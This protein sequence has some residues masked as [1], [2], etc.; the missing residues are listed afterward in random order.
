MNF[1]SIYFNKPFWKTVLPLAIPIALQNLMAASFSLIDTFMVAGLGSTTLSAVGMATQYTWLFNICIF[2][3]TSG[4]ALF[5]SQYWGTKDRDSIN[6]TEGM[7]LLL[8]IGTA[9]MFFLVGLLFPEVILRIFNK[10]ETVITIGSSYIRYACFSYPAYAFNFV[11]YTVLRSTEKVRLPMLL[12]VFNAAVNAFLNYSL[13]Y[14]FGPFPRMEAAG[15]ALATSISCWTTTLLLLTV[16]FIQRNIVVA[17]LGKLFVFTKKHFSSFMRK[18]IPALL[19]EG[20][21]ALG[22]TVLNIILSNISVES[23][24]GVTILRTVENLAFVFIV[25]LCNACSI[26]IGKS[27]GSGDIIGAKKDATRFLCV[28]PLFSII[29]S[30]AMILLRGPLVSLFTFSGEYTDIAI[31]SALYCILIYSL[32]M[33]IRNIPYLTIVGI[34]RP[35][36]DPKTG[37]ICDVSALWFI[38]IPLTA[39]LSFLGVPFEI[40]FLL[41]YLSEDIPKT[42][43]CII[44]YISGKWIHPVTPEGRL[45]LEKLKQND[46]KS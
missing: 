5:V 11:L 19:N 33:P 30:T 6:R 31:K 23:Y 46:Q 22:T 45:A 36:G 39:L 20:V 18:T 3:L 21:F 44:Y 28:M 38:S 15:A 35:G 1:K 13:I 7:A 12:S 40:V 37:M 25:G 34:F 41:M 43:L 32:D 14:G 4:T 16:C 9:L 29:T 2:G 10:D 17:P 8:A 42:I 27:I 24:A 26:I